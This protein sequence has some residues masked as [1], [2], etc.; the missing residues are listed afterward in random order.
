MMKNIKLILEWFRWFCG[1]LLNEVL[2]EM[3]VG[4]AVHRHVRHRGEPQ[5]PQDLRLNNLGE[6]FQDRF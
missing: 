2:D 1:C 5:L 4:D 3:V 6:T